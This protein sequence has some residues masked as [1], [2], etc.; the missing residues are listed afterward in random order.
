VLVAGI[1][2]FA[3]AWV[4]RWFWFDVPEVTTTAARSIVALVVPFQ[5]LAV[6]GVVVVVL[7][8]NRS[9]S[10]VQL[11]VIVLVLAAALPTQL[12]V[13]STNLFDAVAGRPVLAK[14][15]SRVY[16][17]EDEQRAMIWLSEHV[18]PG[19]VAVSNVFCMPAPYRPGCPDDAF[20]ISGLSGVQQYLGGW[21]YAPKN[22]EAT[23]NK[24]SFLLQPPPWPD[25]LQLSLAA[26]RRPTPALLSKL[27]DEIGVDWIIADLRA[28]P[29]SPALDK[30]A[31]RAYAN[32][33]V[34]IYRLR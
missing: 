26:V 27:R 18:E 9:R 33:D 24:T 16:L 22:L 2:G 17:T 31:E 11:Q 13:F 32:S 10:L 3:T 29:V 5:V 7:T 6:V 12:V 14:T 28:G 8:R 30:L 19:D 21:A 25:R 1:A 23:Q 34:R 4:I 20:W 15:D